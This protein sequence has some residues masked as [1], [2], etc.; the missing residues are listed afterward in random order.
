LDKKRDIGVLKSMGAPENTIF[1]V[2]F[3]Q[4]SYIALI[5]GGVGI[6]LAMILVWSQQALGWFTIENA[7]ISE[8]P[9]ELLGQD[10]VLTLSTIFI[11]GSFISL[12]PAYKA[13]KTPI[14]AIN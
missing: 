8:Y 10:I 4:G 9:V 5:G 7:I 3:W 1:K 2:F 12:Y 13:S 6:L 11:L 14:L